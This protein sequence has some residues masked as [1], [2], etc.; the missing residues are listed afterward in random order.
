MYRINNYSEQVE[1]DKKFYIN[2]IQ[3]RRVL[4]KVLVLLISIFFFHCFY[5]K[6]EN[7]LLKSF[8][9]LVP[10]VSFVIAVTIYPEQEVCQ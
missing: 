3:H 4:K 10:K 6:L 8:N 1:I 2:S 5:L 7:F 9:L